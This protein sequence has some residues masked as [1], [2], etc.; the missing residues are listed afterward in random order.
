MLS[1]RFAG[2]RVSTNVL[3]RDLDIS[4]PH[5]SDGRRFE[6]VAEEL[7]LFGL[8]QLALDATVVSTFH[9]DG[10]HRRK[11]DVEDGVALNEARRSTE[12][13]VLLV[14]SR[15]WKSTTCGHSRKGRRQVVSRNKG[16]LVVFCLREVQVFSQVV[17]RKRQSLLVQEVV[18]FPCVFNGEGSGLRF[19]WAPRIPWVK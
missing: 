5:S 10:T 19:G 3:L 9:G 6:V 15:W 16:L 4:P 8:C 13:H 18:L 1:L 11:S 7:C 2:A 17:A 12:G 14:V